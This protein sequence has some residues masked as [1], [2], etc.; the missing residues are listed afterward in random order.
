RVTRPDVRPEL[1]AIVRRCLEKSPDRRFSTVTELAVAL[2][3]YGTQ[4]STALVQRFAP[5]APIASA[6]ASSR[7]TAFAMLAVAVGVLSVAVVGFVLVRTKRAPHPS[8]HAD[9]APSASVVAAETPP[10]A[11]ETSSLP[12]VAPSAATSPSTTAK[13]RATNTRRGPRAPA[14]PSA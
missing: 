13:P 7:P 6:P 2:A 5:V 14:Q 8:A 3:P 9:I 12:A 4:Q 10:K 1:D 11:V